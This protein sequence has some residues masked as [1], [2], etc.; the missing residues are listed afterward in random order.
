MIRRL[1]LIKV[2]LPIVQHQ[3]QGEDPLRRELIGNPYR[4]RTC[5]DYNIIFKEPK[6]KDCRSN[7]MHVIDHVLLV[8]LDLI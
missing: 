1:V 4:S 2:T 6:E 5:V 3:F 8:F 7:S